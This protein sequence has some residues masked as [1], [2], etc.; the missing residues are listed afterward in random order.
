MICQ[1]CG[2]REVNF[3]YTSNINGCVTETHLCS[4][5]AAKSGYNIGKLFDQSSIFDRFFPLINRR[6]SFLP[7]ALPIT[8]VNRVLPSVTNQRIGEVAQKSA[9]DCGCPTSTAYTKADG[10]DDEMRKRRELYMEMNIAAEN[11]NFEKAAEL[12]DKLKNMEE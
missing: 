9:C 3:H 4:E 1:D 10:V 12:R 7:A 5:C 8:G 2:K 6:G 11:E